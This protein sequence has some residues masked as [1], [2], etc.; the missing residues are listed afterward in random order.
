MTD[1]GIPQICPV[2][3]LAYPEL[4]EKMRWCAP[5]ILSSYA[6]GGTQIIWSFGMIIY[7]RL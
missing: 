3:D 5:E 6:E 7:V 4:I 1:T 2:G